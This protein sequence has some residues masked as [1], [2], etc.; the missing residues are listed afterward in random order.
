MALGSASIAAWGNA[1]KKVYASE[2]ARKLLYE[3]SPVLAMIS[4]AN[5]FVGLTYNVDV[6]IGG[7]QGVSSNLT[8]SIAGASSSNNRM[9]SL[10]RGALYGTGRIDRELMMAAASAG[11]SAIF[12]ALKNERDTLNLAAGRRLSR[13]IFQDGTG[14]IGQVGSISTNTITLVRPE[15]VIWY[16]LDDIVQFAQSPLGSV[17][18]T[19]TLQVSAVNRDTGVVTFTTNVTAGISAA[20]ATDFIFSNGDN[21]ADAGAR[22]LTGF[23]AWLP[24]S[25]VSAT[26]FFGVDRT[27]DPVRLAGMSYIGNGALKLQSIR[28]AMPK[29]YINAATKTKLCVVSPIDYAD[30]CTSLDSSTRFD[31]ISGGDK[32]V[33]VGFEVM[34]IQAPG[35]TLNIVQDSSCPTGVFYLLDMSTWKLHTL[36]E[37]KNF[38]EVV[39]QDGNEFRMDPNTDSFTWRLAGYAQL[40]CNAPGKNLRGTF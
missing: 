39:N 5:D 28:T 11:G 31:R 17:S 13:W 37:G 29:V 36:T 16:E 19:G 3:T 6:V 2:D 4:K 7:Q 38:P 8:A 25:G 18:R 14:N 34:T 10:T 40:A 33:S 32:S 1:L 30:M 15:D 26:A 35:G 20:V 12:G 22:P 23:A 24:G 27:V 21:A 9:F